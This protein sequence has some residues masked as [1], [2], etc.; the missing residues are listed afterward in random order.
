MESCA[1]FDVS[2][3]NRLFLPNSLDEAHA[4]PWNISNA[5]EAESGISPF[6]QATPVDGIPFSAI[7]TSGHYQIRIPVDALY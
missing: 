5:L 2:S 7:E 4:A 1:A 3:G 6:E